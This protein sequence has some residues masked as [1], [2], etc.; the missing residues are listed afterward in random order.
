M[1]HLANIFALHQQGG[2]GTGGAG[3]VGGSGGAA[4]TPEQVKE[5][6]E[7]HGLEKKRLSDEAAKERIAK[8][9]ERDEKLA[10][11]AER[12]A[13]L[14]E[15][16]E[17]KAKA[18]ATGSGDD[19]VQIPKEVELRMK[20]LEDQLAKNAE[21]SRR[22]EKESAERARLLERDAAISERITAAQVLPELQEAIRSFIEKNT[23]IEEDGSKIFKG[24]N[25]KGETIEVPLT[26]L[27]LHEI[28][29]AAAFPAKA[30]GGSG[31]RT[32]AGAGGGKGDQ[33]SR[34]YTQAEW[35]KMSPDER[36]AIQRKRME[37]QGVR[38]R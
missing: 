20:S 12:D 2:T 28:V 35:D 3:D 14:K 18:G 25:L 11:Q 8:N 15:R 33:V 21:E 32:P 37:A 34:D 29:S 30:G 16:D 9:K 10:I 24:K 22:K 17:L 19:K 13:L 26:D 23:K 27:D 7:K 4:L 5:L 36:K 6:E 31:G 38:V 1:R